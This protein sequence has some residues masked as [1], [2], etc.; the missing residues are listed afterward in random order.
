MSNP[1]QDKCG[2]LESKANRKL[3]GRNLINSMHVKSTIEWIII[4]W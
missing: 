1:D 4:E 2:E 3:S